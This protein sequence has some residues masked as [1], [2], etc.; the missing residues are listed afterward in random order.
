MSSEEGIEL[1]VHDGDDA[2]DGL[3]AAPGLG[4]PVGVEGRFGEREGL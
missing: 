3:V 2:V 1:G 4:L